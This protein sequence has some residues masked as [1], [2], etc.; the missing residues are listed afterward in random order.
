MG[1]K[2]QDK[3]SVR[4]SVAVPKGLVQ[5]LRDLAFFGGSEINPKAWIEKEVLESA[6][7]TI[8]AFSDDEYLVAAR[9][10]VKYGL[11][12]KTEEDP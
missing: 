2:F 1:R 3:G 11:S 6:R 12:E 8:D 10:K 5:F 4:L 7:A 9:L